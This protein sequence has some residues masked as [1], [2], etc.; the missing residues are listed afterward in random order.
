[1]TTD[2]NG[3]TES[4]Q[5]IQ[6]MVREFAR[7]EIAPGAE[8]RDRTSVFDYGLL[9]RLGELGLQGMVFPEEYGGT[10]TDSLSFCLAIEEISRVDMSLG[11]TLW[12]GVQGGQSMVRGSDEQLDAWR[13]R[14]IV[15]T[16]RGEVVSAGA[17][18]E[19]DAGSDTAAL[20]TRARRDGDDW[21][22]DGAKIFISNAGL[23]NCAFAMVLCR[24]DDGF[25]I[26]IVPTGTPGY[27]IGRPLR[28]MGLRS[29]DTRELSFDSCRVPAMHLLGGSGSGRQAIVSGGFHITRLFIA[30]QAVGVAAECLDLSLAHAK[31]RVAFKKPLSRFEYVQGMLVDMAL[32]IEMARLLRDKACRMHDARLPYAKEAAMTKLFCSEMAKRAADHA[33]QLFGGMGY[34]DETPVSRYYRDI[35]AATIAEGTSEIQKY[36]IAREMGCFE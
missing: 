10:N 11:L 31:T 33:V 5:Q 32:E 24:T 4:Q 18:T 27:T 35:R 25:G 19:P 15:P 20:R 3:Y 1:M 13:D 7:R 26:I 23:D 30:S 8:E 36:I 14:Y 22:I 29:S 6:A 28:K 34:M 2:V 12:V 21:V 16:V 9:R 17:I